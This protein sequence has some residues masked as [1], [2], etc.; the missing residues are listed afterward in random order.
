MAGPADDGLDAA[1]LDAAVRRLADR[2]ERHREDLNRLNVYPV[3]DGDTGDNLVATLRVVTGRLPEHADRAGVIDAVA[4]GGL[5]G[6]RGSSGVILGQALRGFVTALPEVCDGDGLAAALEVAARAARRAVA[7][8]VEGTIL[9]VADD[10]ARAARSASPT[11][12]HSSSPEESDSVCDSGGVDDLPAGSLAEV[13]RAAATE[14]RLSLART[15]SLLPQLARAGVVDAGGLGYVLFLDALAEI[16]TGRESPPLDL[17]PSHV[18]PRVADEI[19]EAPAHAAAHSRRFEVVC[20]LDAEADRVENLRRRWVTIGDTVAIAGGG[21]SWRAHVHTDDMAAALA[22]AEESGRVSDVEI[23]DLAEQTST[24]RGLHRVDP[25][26]DPSETPWERRPALVAVAEGEGL[27]AAYLEAGVER[28]VI[29]G[30]TT[31]PATGQLLAVLEACAGPVVLLCGD[32]DVVPAAERA[33]EAAH[34]PTC[35]VPADMVSALLALEGLTSAGPASD[36]ERAG[37]VAALSD[38]LRGRAEAIREVRVQSAVRDAPTGLGPVRHGEWLAMGRRGPVAIGPSAQDAVL[39]AAGVLVDPD[40]T[41]GVLT[42]DAESSDGDE[43]L[44]ALAGAHPS[45]TWRMRRT[46]RPS[47]AYGLLVA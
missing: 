10:A 30:I 42:L 15:P 5:L 18:A 9:T 23:T 37:D 25:S 33:A 41:T 47:C 1:L 2:L 14:G 16:L 34:V 4:T 8:P 22:A 6:G 39:R 17:T 43:L 44:A 29:G 31:K 21:T 12:T 27:I 32:K 19:A 3:P 46:N 20:R 13:A 26:R 7:D 38:R 35:I 45:L 40:S 36:G 11:G 28:V 24:E